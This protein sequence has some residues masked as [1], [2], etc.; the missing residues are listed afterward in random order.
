[1]PE[2]TKAALRTAAVIALRHIDEVNV[3]QREQVL[4]ALVEVLPEAEAA[5]ANEALI[6]LR[7]CRRLQMQLTGLLLGVA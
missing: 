6:A 4:V 3:A 1:V 7:E 5:V 2:T